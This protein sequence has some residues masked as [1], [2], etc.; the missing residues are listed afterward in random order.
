MRF[1]TESI[2]RLD[3]GWPLTIRSTIRRYADSSESTSFGIVPFVL[4]LISALPKSV[5]SDIIVGPNEIRVKQNCPRIVAPAFDFVHFSFRK[6][7]RNVGRWLLTNRA[8]QF[9]GSGRDYE[10]CVR[11]ADGAGHCPTVL[12]PRWTE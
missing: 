12:L 3:A 10:I 11:V 6:H 8:G 4:G 2:C 7:R 5:S 9:V 1:K